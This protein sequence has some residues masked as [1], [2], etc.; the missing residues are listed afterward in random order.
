MVKSLNPTGVELYICIYVFRS[1]ILD[2]LKLEAGK[3]AEK[4]ALPN[5]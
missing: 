3:P 1:L 2:R 4:L 5:D